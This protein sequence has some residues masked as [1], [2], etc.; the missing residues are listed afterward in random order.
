VAAHTVAAKPTKAA[1]SM[2]RHITAVGAKFVQPGPGPDNSI[3]IITPE[4]AKYLHHVVE[5]M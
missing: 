2:R 5:D 3:E 4:T 1:T